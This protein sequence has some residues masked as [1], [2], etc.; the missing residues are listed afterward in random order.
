MDSR[1]SA[2]AGETRVDRD[3]GSTSAAPRCHSETTRTGGGRARDMITNTHYHQE[4]CVSHL[5]VTLIPSR[6]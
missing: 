2:G 6:L 5:T 4:L 1:I 3:L